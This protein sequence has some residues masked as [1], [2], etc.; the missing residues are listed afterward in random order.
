MTS[1]AVPGA[2]VVGGAHVSIGIARSLGRRGIPVW[3]LANHPIPKFSRYVKRSFDWSGADHPDGLGQIIDVAVKNDLAGWVLI[4][5]GDQD[6]RLVAQ[7]HEMLSKRLHVAACDWATI[8]WVYDKRLTHRR[9][10]SLGIDVP[11]SFEPRDLDDVRALDCRFPVILKPAY[12]KGA[13]AFTLAKAWRADDRETLLALYRRAS[14]LVG[15]DAVIVQEWIPGTGAAQFSCAGLWERGTPIA[16]LTARRRRQH[17]VDFGRSSTFVETIA[18]DEIESLACRFMQSLDY[19]GVAEIEFKYDARE[20]RYKLLD[21]NGRFWTWCGIGALAGMDF[22]YLAYRQALGE[23]A[24]SGRARPG[25]AWVHARSDIKAAWQELRRGSLTLRDYVSGFRQP[26]TFASF[27]AD[28]PLPALMEMPAA[29]LNRL[30]ARVSF[31]GF[32][33]GRRP[34]RPA[35]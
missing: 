26:L 4:P 18:H 34:L 29:A 15:S 12:R 13:D 1:T 35:K 31:G 17:P 20:K 16:L 11:W 7:N 3:L 19:T 8:Q 5:T 32:G 24:A 10:H 30:A 6:L 27:A 33:G 22:P 14:A 2:L 23:T 21:V 28:D 9:A 25:V